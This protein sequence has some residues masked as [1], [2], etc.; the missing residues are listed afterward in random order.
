MIDALAFLH[1]YASV[2]PTS[3]KRH[4]YLQEGT[5]CLGKWNEVME[6]MMR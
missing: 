3:Q 6:Q 5:I 4:Y 2:I 1:F